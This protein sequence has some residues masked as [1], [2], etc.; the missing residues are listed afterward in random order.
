MY[1]LMRRDEIKNSNIPNMRVCTCTELKGGVYA[2][3]GDISKPICW[4]LHHE[5]KPT[6]S[7]LIRTLVKQPHR[8]R[9]LDVTV[10]YGGSASAHSHRFPWVVRNVNTSPLPDTGRVVCVVQCRFE[11]EPHIETYHVARPVPCPKTAGLLT[12]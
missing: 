5:R 6:T 2:A 3:H 12:T 8:P 11:S 10:K 1:C 9:K 4:V 7:P